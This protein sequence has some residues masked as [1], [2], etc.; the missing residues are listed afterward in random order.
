M[1]GDNNQELQPTDLGKFHCSLDISDPG[2]DRVDDCRK[3]Q[4][5]DIVVNARM[6]FICNFPFAQ[7][8]CRQSPGK[9]PQMA[10]VLGR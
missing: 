10:T 5:S 3:A 6:D 1:F 7:S 9:M 8:G 4:V 2:K